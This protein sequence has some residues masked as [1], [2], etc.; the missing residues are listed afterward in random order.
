MERKTHVQDLQ[1]HRTDA[2]EKYSRAIAKL[3]DQRDDA[4]FDAPIIPGDL[5]MREVPNPQSKL[6]P[7]WDGPCVVLASSEKDVYQLATANGY[8]IRNLVN[9]ARLRKLSIDERTRYQ[10]EFWNA[11]ERLKTHDERARRED[12]L[13]DVNKRLSQATLD[14]LEAQKVQQTQRQDPDSSTVPP[15]TTKIAEG[16]S[17]I[18]ALSQE[19]RDLEKALAAS[20]KSTSK[21]PESSTSSGKYLQKLSWKLC[22]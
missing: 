15:T 16:M 1:Q 2:A 18:A 13:A 22:D 21:T 20:T 12:E 10:N 11:S 17:K 19:K 8:T 7:K 14:H 5:V 3:A 6:H 4:G 9:I